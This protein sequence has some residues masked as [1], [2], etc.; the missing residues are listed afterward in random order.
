M[1]GILKNVARVLA[2][3]GCLAILALPNLASAQSAEVEV[4]GAG[5]SVRVTVFQNPDFTTETRVSERGAITFPLIGEVV[6][7]GLTP[8]QA[9]ARIAERLV[10]G[11]FISKPQV[12]LNL[13]QVRSRQVSVLGE[14]ARPGRY[15]LEASNLSLTD[16]LAL[17]G[18]ITTT[19][20]ERVT[21][22][23]NRGGQSE[24]VEVN[25]GDIARAGDLSRDLRIENGDKIF[26]PRAPVFYVFGQVQ[27]AGVY[28]LEPAM[29]VMQGL[30]VGGS[31][32]PRGSLRGLKVHRKSQDGK[33]VAAEVGLTDPIRANDVIY[34]EESFF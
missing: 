25:V 31:V 30:S 29:T 12:T 6:V 24:S 16:V 27:R 19:G 5:D 18:G 26:V 9:E 7:S 13:L 34:V 33:V 20:Y 28:R 11:R 32:T 8:V 3:L 15:A 23:R 4:L 22:V 1:N 2:T 17:A 10:A 21:V 14:V